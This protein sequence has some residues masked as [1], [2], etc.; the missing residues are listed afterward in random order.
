MAIQMQ[1]RTLVHHLLALLVV[2]G[3]ASEA[4]DT[5]ATSTPEVG[6]EHQQRRGWRHNNRTLTPPVIRNFI[7][8]DTLYDGEWER[9]LHVNGITAKET[10][11][12]TILPSGER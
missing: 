5:S 2:A 1:Q 10:A 9:R 4:L 6:G 3:A 8:T 11:V 12:N 7:A